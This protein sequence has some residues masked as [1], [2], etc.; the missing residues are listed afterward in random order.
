MRSRDACMMKVMPMTADHGTPL[1]R[2]APPNAIMGDT[3]L[4]LMLLTL[5]NDHPPLAIF[6]GYSCSM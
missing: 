1:V 6:D 3:E 2:L 4:I 5:A